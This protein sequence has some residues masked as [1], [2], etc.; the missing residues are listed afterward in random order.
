MIR[1]QVLTS[2]QELARAASWFIQHKLLE[3]SRKRGRV[4]LALSG[5]STPLPV[6]KRLAKLALPWNN[7]HL[8]WGDER[9]VP[10]DH[11]NSNFGNAC[12]A[13][14]DRVPIPEAN[15]HRIQ[16]ELEPAEA[17]ES[18]EHDLRQFFGPE[19]PSMDLVLL[20]MGADGH[21]ASLFPGGPELEEY[22]RWVVGSVPPQGIEP[23]VPRVTCTF[24][25]FNAA[26]SV[27]FLV[28]GADKR[29]AT[30]RI[31]RV[32]GNGRELPAGRVRPKGELAWFLD[33]D[34]APGV[35]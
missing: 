19:P 16:G 18:Y 26:R 20:G 34:A 27:L 9:C 1:V 35:S 33:S 11:Q 12:R 15:V 29:P 3:A 10:P 14:I 6:Y 4:L 5:G 32:L 8:F 7:L 31:L 30:S 24:P 17:A 28:A 22:Q 23:D 21:T 25:V 2:A 13:L